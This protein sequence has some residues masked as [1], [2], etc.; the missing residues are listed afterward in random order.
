MIRKILSVKEKSLR[1]RSREVTKIDKKILELIEDMQDTLAAQQDPEG[2]GLAAPQIGKNLRIFLMKYDGK[3]KIVINPKIS[4][5]DETKEVAKKGK[6]KKREKLL[7]GCLSLPHYYGPLKRSR[8]LTLTYQDETG[9]KVTESFTGFL[10][11]IVQ[12]EVD[13]LDGILFIDR[14]LE[15]SAPLYHFH[16]DEWEEVE[17]V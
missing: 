8:K 1:E 4:D 15:Q 3:E 12:H 7:E 16:G 10:A 2:V 6:G 13:H 17:L 5:M 14:I 9:K 11:Q